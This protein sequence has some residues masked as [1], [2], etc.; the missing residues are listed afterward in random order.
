M[1]IFSEWTLALYAWNKEE[2]QKDLI[3]PAKSFWKQLLVFTAPFPQLD[4][5]ICM[6]PL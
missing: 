3:Y 2:M 1:A 6:L 4:S 5:A